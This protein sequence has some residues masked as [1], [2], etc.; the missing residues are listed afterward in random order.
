LLAEEEP[1]LP[2]I[3]TQEAELPTIDETV[4]DTAPATDLLE[5]AD[6]AVK[7]I[8]PLR[9]GIKLYNVY[10][11]EADEWSRR[12]CTGLAEWALEYH[13]PVHDQAEALAHSLAG[14]SATVGFQPLSDIARALEHA[15][16]AVSSHQEAGYPATETQ[17]RLFVEA[18][19]EIRRLLHQFAAGFYKEPSAELL[20]ALFEVVHAP[21]PA[22]PPAVAAD[23]VSAES[24]GLELDETDLQA[25]EPE[26]SSEPVVADIAPFEPV[27]AAQDP[28]TEWATLSE[29]SAAGVQDID[30]DIDVVD[31][32]D[33]DLFP[34]FEEEA[35]ELLP[36]WAVLF[37]SGRHDPTM[38]GPARKCCGP[39]IPSRAVRVWPVPCVWV[40][41]CTAWKPMRS[42]WAVK[43]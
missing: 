32:I 9:I 8:G 27:R 39:C 38:R 11:N 31:T 6:D 43:G 33:V 23:E 42:D 7:V 4:A 21:L 30:D 22:E 28:I 24:E 20:A 16:G 17:A 10:L 25:F 26:A 40:K 34:I 35:L 14:S 1:P 15:I 18:S 37:G 5:S 13:E 36:S 29:A 12:L 2:S 3:V 41:W 19:E